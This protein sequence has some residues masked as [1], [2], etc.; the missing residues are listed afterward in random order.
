MAGVGVTTRSRKPSAK[1]KAATEDQ[2]M[3]SE[4]Y[5]GM[6]E[7]LQRMHALVEPVMLLLKQVLENQKKE[8]EERQNREREQEKRHAEELIAIREELAALREDSTQARLNAQLGVPSSMTYAQS[9]STG[10]TPSESAS[11]QAN[12][13]TQRKGTRT[14]NQIYCTIDSSRVVEE[15]REKTQPKALKQAIEQELRKNDGKSNWTCVAVTKDPRIES[16]IRITCRNEVERVQVRDAAAKICTNGSRLMRDQLY[17]VKLDNAC[18]ASVL[19]LEGGLRNNVMKELSEEN[20]VE[21]AKIV[22]LSD[23][24]RTREYGSMEIYLTQTSDAS[25]ILHEG[26]FHLNGESAY[27]NPFEIRYNPIQCYRCQGLNHKAFSCKKEQ[28]CA[29]CAGQGHTHKECE[30]IRVPKCALCNGPHEAFSKN[31]QML[32]P[33]PSHG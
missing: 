9:L 31:C 6:D 22:W 17:P 14:Q 13:N 27:T 25:R 15:D 5:T 28:V 26:Y 21:I 19:T 33:R 11:L 30:E 16:R 20:N 10:P 3:E 7:Y 1:A 24:T 32:H 8:S 2:E 4:E 29:K 23:K 12:R 18:R